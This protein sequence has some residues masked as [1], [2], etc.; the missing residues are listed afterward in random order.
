MEKLHNLSSGTP[1]ENSP[2][3]SR[4]ILRG[5][6]PIANAF[7]VERLQMFCRL[8]A[9]RYR[10]SRRRKSS[11]HPG[12]VHLPKRTRRVGCKRINPHLGMMW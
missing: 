2:G 10:L 9:P 1:G 7:L 12:S 3:F 8:P 5:E 4:F 6:P 11:P